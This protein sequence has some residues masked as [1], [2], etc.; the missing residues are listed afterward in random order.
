MLA[1]IRYFCLCITR[2][3][4]LPCSRTPTRIIVTS[5]SWNSIIS[6]IVVEW[7]ALTKVSVV[8][9]CFIYVGLY[10]TIYLMAKTTFS[11]ALIWSYWLAYD[12]RGFPSEA[13]RAWTG[14]CCSYQ[15]CVQRFGHLC[16]LSTG[17]MSLSCPCFFSPK[18][19]AMYS[20]HVQYM[21]NL[22]HVDDNFVYAWCHRI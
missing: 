7:I 14:C 2:I 22:L 13:A 16:F 12:L 1:V 11:A 6:K 19:V 15:F 4:I 21:C 5:V 10:V 17:G 20:C 18:S 8:G 3:A 9:L